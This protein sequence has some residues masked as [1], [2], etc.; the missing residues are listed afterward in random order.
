[1]TN[2]STIAAARTPA[3]TISVRGK[4]I[5]CAPQPLQGS[6]SGL[7]AQGIAVH[8]E[9]GKT[10]P[11][12][13]PLAKRDS[14]TR[15]VSTVPFS[16]HWP[17]NSLAGWYAKFE[18]GTK[19]AHWLAVGVPCGLRGALDLQ[20]KLE[21]LCRVIATPRAMRLIKEMALAL[22]IALGAEGAAK[23]TETGLTLLGKSWPLH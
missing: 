13:E 18:P 23:I 17:K 3:R 12:S 9:E 2:A 5:T 6:G 10:L 22:G 16:R 7:S 15:S 21:I 11:S 14:L 20:G 1:M 4:S 8:V 19:L